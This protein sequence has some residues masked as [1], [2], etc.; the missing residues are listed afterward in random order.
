MMQLIQINNLG[1]ISEIIISNE[2]KRN[3]LSTLLLNEFIDALDQAESTPIRVLII[4][5][6]KGC[7]VWSSGFNIK[8]LPMPG[9]DPVP[10]NHPI[11]QLIRRLQEVK[12]PLIAMIEGS[13]WGG[14]CDIALSCDILIGT[15][16]SSFAITP[17]KIG[18]PYNSL[19]IQRILNRMHPNIAK[20]L[21]F[22]AQPMSAE[23]AYELGIL[24]HIVSS[25][26]LESF[27][28]EMANT[29]AANS[30]LSISVIKKQ[31]E[32]LSRSKP[33]AVETLSL[34][35]ELRQI[36][37]NSEDYKEGKLAF[38][39]KRTAKFIGK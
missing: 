26:S 34:I 35:D 38:D 3:S 13:V 33:I 24:N 22:T 21:F 5:A 17:A 25:E 15:S 30:P 8:E 28:Y 10:Y 14:A 31:I 12:I 2:E 29:I 16:K 6:A 18:V 36:A 23:R 1:N 19:G 20:E 32:M 37:Y 11:E 9:I 7:K 4:R 39:E 27:T